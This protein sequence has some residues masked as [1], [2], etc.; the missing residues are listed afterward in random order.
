MYSIDYILQKG[1]R[2]EAFLVQSYPS[3]EV[4]KEVPPL[5][6][7]GWTQGDGPCGMCLHIFIMIIMNLRILLKLEVTVI[8][9]IYSQACD[10][11]E[12]DEVTTH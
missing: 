11:P 8:V 6:V 7:A 5:G 2:S 9:V 1:E 4:H 12:R 3:G 10:Y